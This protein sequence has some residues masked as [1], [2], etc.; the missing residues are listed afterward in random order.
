MSAQCRSALALIETMTL[1]PDALAPTDVA[2]ARDA[3]VSD[4]AI[5]DAATICALFNVIDR[6]ADAFGFHVP[7]QAE[8]D[9]SAGF[10]L[11]RGYVLPPPVR[12]FARD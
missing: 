12:W 10:L 9:A 7:E 5:E 2:A 3:G 8:F 6:L 4:A 1:Q 11:R